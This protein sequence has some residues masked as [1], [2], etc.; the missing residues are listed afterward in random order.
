MSVC[1]MNSVSLLD[2]LTISHTYESY[3]SFQNSQPKQPLLG[4]LQHT[5]NLLKEKCLTLEDL[6]INAELKQLHTNHLINLY[7]NYHV[8]V[9]KI[10]YF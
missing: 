4:K 3:N 8:N 9:S 1:N 10:Q 5:N 7:K 2:L 6:Q